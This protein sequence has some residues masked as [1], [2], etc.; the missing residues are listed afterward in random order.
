MKGLVGINGC[1][2]DYNHA[3]G[4]SITEKKQLC[5]NG[6]SNVSSPSNLRKV[7]GLDA[8]GSMGIFQV[9]GRSALVKQGAAMQLT[10]SYK[11]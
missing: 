2:C 9:Q 3:H 1:N 11:L 8:M 4:P 10:K 7:W 6:F 5:S